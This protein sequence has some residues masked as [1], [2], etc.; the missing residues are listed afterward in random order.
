M[1]EIWGCSVAGWGVALD[2][3][4]GFWVRVLAGAAFI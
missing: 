1:L 4:Q 3:M 2:L